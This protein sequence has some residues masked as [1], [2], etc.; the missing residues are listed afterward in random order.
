M[1]TIP[2]R[3]RRAT[4]WTAPRPG[5][6]GSRGAPP[7]GACSPRWS[8][9]RSPPSRPPAPRATRCRRPPRTAPR[10]PWPSSP[11]STISAPPSPRSTRPGRWRPSGGSSARTPTGVSPPHAGARARATRSRSPAAS[12]RPPAPTPSP[13]RDAWSSSSPGPPPRCVAGASPRSRPP[14]SRPRWTG[15]HRRPA[16]GSTASSPRTRKRCRDA[17]ASAW[18]PT[19]A[20]WSSS[21][22]PRA[23]GTGPSARRGPG[24]SP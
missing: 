10:R 3:A 12:P 6:R 14:R 24:I 9:R 7:H 23:P 20:G 8:P 21:S 4:S 19:C 1:G 2:A 11:G 15:R 16:P 5:S 22:S 17:G 13:P 18:P